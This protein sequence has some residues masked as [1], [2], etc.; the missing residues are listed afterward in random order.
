MVV[1]EALNHQRVGS[2][3]DHL[4]NGVIEGILVLLQPSSQIVRHSG[5]IVDNSKMRIRVRL[6]V[7]LGKVSP[8]SKKISMKL[9]TEGFI[10]SLG[11][12]RLFLKDGKK[13]HGLLKH[14]NTF[15][16]IHTKVNIGPVKTFLDIFLLLK[17]EH[18]LV[19]ELLQLL[20]DI[21][22]TDL[23]KA[24]VVKD[25]K[26]GNIQDTNVLDFLHGRVNKGLITLI[27]NNSEG[28]LIDGTSNTSN[29]VGGS[30]TGRTLLD[31][32]S[33]DLQL[34]LA[35]VGDHPLTVNASK[36]GNLLG[37][38][39][40][41][42]FS[43]LFLANWDKVLGHVTHVH[44]ASSVLEHIILLSL[45]ETKD[46][47][48]FIG[49][50]HVFL[51]INGGDSELAL[52]DIP[53]VQDVIG[54]QT[55]LLKVRNRVRHQVIEGV[56]ASL[57]GLLVGQTGLLKEVDN[58][59]SSRQLTRGIEV[60]TDELTKSG[61]VVIS[62]SLGIT[63]G[64]QD[65]VGLDNLVLKGGLSLLPL[66]R[67]ADG[68]KVGDDLLGVLSLSSTRLTG[69]ENRLVGARVHHAL[70]GSLSNGKD[71]GR[72]LITSLTNIQLHGTESVDGES[73]VGVDGNTEETR[74]GV[75]E[76]V[77]VSD[78]RVPQDTGITKV[79]EASHVL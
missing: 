44:H 47:K 52:G 4:N 25:L 32:L 64:F 37:I 58:H 62:H 26:A 67:G 51:V 9:G 19:E 40:I 23:F 72:A 59:V 53:V 7:W 33:T 17:G 21:V 36:S 77:D 10:S 61:G 54:K 28:T 56:V 65:R 11:E 78:L 75:D 34:G 48:G 68:G 18:V 49:K 41:L 42:D 38:N 6:R 69:N 76:L 60:D 57:K 66:A 5:G 39:I 46:I 13:S 24:I 1:S 16:K 2:I 79:G 43:L 14:V 30:S 74:V 73:L 50:V 71:V 70:V 15:L 20:I 29:R 55:L 63:P 35:E 31:P 12:E 45:S 3:L 27:H 8:F 22:D